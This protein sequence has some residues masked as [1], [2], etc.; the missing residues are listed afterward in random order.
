[1]HRQKLEALSLLAGA[2]LAIVYV[3]RGSTYLAIRIMDEEMPPLVSAGVRFLTAGLLVGGA[4]A[5]RG[6]LGRLAVT[7]RQLLGCAQIRLLLLVMGL[8]TPGG[9]RTSR[10][11]QCAGPDARRTPR[12]AR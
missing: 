4:L 5:G 9:W 1:M 10:R 8:V 2:A 12:R 11:K 7:R 3:A 6:G